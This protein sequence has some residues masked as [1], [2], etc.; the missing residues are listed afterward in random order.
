MNQELRRLEV[1]HNCQSVRPWA[2]KLPWGLDLL[3]RAFRHGRNRTVCEFFYEISEVS[4]IT[5]EQRLLGARNIGTTS[6]KNIEAVLDKQKKDFNLG[7]RVQQFKDLMG[8]GVFTQEGTDWQHS[9]YLLRHLVTSNR[10]HAFEDIQRCAENMLDPIVPYTIVDLQPLIF[11]L[12]LATTLFMLFG[13]SAHNMLA[14]GHKEGFDLNT[15][16]NNAQEYLAYRTRVGPFHW[17]INGP[18]MW[19][20]CRTLHSFIDGAIEEALSAPGKNNRHSFVDELI[21]ETRDPIILRD[22]CVSLLLAGRDSTAACLSWTMRLIGRHPEVLARLRE[23]IASIVG[24]GPDARHRRPTQEQLKQMKYLNLTIKE[25]LRLYP[26]IP[27]NQRAATCTTTLPEG[28]G[29]DGKSPVLVRQGES[30]GFSAYVMHR[31]RDIYGEDALEFRPERW[32]NEALSG[33]GLGYLPWGYG[34]RACLG[35]DFALLEATYTV[36]RIIQRFPYITL[37]EGETIGIGEEK[38]LLTLILS[39]AEGCK[40]RLN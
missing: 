5:H 17:L 36:A 35:R 31:S 29:P 20:A 24:V 27:V 3:F 33:V 37:P 14:S 22:Q 40:L 25:S 19:R 16:F 2:A 10:A 9:R 13:D 6:P 28:G 11:Q 8:S 15:A 26:P 30:V 32:E 23:E 4:G 21:Q 1:K 18:S 12:T 34:Q 7:F 38:Q 39:S